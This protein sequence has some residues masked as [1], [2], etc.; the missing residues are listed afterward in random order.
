MRR[1]HRVLGLTLILPLALWVLTGLLFH[2]KH[3]YDEAYE[4]LAVPHV[5]QPDWSKAKT[6]PASVIERGIAESPLVLAVHPSGR[7]AYYGKLGTKP[8]AVDAANGEEIPQ[9][10][11][12]EGRAWIEA[13]LANSAHAARYGRVVASE[14]T[15]SRSARTGTQDPALALHLSGSK[16]VHVDLITGEIAQTGALKDFIDA[17]Y[18][19]HYLQWTQGKPINI[20]LELVSVAIS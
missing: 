10:S 7:L 9:A 6:S 16:V 8:V 19:L 3:R 15:T 14:V 1:F 20:L 12:D 18:R 13:A 5:L 2:V 17:T 11:P 4:A